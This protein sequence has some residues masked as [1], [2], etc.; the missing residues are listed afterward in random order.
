MII[1]MM[2]NNDDDRAIEVK[3]GAYELNV[4]Y[5]DKQRKKMCKYDDSDDNEDN[6]K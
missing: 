3:T 2:T 5:K 1:M 6:D 4:E